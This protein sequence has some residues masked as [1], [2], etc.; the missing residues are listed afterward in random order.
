M[1]NIHASITH[2]GSTKGYTKR[3][4]GYPYSLLSPNL[5]INVVDLG[6]VRSCGLPYDMGVILD[7]NLG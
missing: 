7:S 6:F 5:R 2:R 3:R 4:N 1:I